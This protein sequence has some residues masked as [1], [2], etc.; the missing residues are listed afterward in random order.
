MPGYL[1]LRQLDEFLARSAGDYPV[2]WIDDGRE[3]FGHLAS[4]GETPTEAAAEER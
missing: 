2:Q 4:A 1:T 3:R